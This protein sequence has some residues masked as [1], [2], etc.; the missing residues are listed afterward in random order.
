MADVIICL[1]FAAYAS[2]TPLIAKLSP[3]QPPDVKII[4]FGLAPNFAAISAL[5]FSSAF[6]ASNALV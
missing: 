4:S 6:F 5:A 3:S 1:P 2:A